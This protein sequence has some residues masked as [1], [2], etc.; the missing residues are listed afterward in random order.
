MWLSNFLQHLERRSKKSGSTTEISPSVDFLSSGVRNFRTVA[1]P[2]V[3]NKTLQKSLFSFLPCQSLLTKNDG[4]VKKL[5]NK[6]P[7]HSVGFHFGI[8]PISPP[9]KNSP[10]PPFFPK[11]KKN[12]NRWKKKSHSLWAR[13]FGTIFF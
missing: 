9:R 7:K 1:P 3:K 2:R 5:P 11:L 13:T 10:P 12:Q 8:L 4:G 6:T